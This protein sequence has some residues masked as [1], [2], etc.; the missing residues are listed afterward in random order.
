M[1]KLFASV[2][3]IAM[4]STAAF[5]GT[6]ADDCSTFEECKAVAIAAEG[7]V[8]S[9]EQDIEQY[10]DLYTEA[11]ATAQAEVAKVQGLQ[12]EIVTYYNLLAEANAEI[13]E[14]EDDAYA[15]GV[16][17]GHV[18]GH[19]EGFEAATEVVAEFYNTWISGSDKSLEDMIADLEAEWS[20]G[21]AEAAENAAF[22][23]GY[24][25]GYSSGYG[26]AESDYE[27]QIEDLEATISGYLS[28]LAAYIEYWGGTVRDA[29]DS[30]KLVNDLRLTGIM[31]GKAE[32]AE[33][34]ADLETEV[35]DIQDA[36]NDL[37]SSWSISLSDPSNIPLAIEKIADKANLAG[38]YEGLEVGNEDAEAAYDLA[39]N[40]IVT[41]FNEAFNNEFPTYITFG[42][43][44]NDIVE[45][46]SNAAYSKVSSEFNQLIKNEGFQLQHAGGS[47]WILSNSAGSWIVDLGDIA[48]QA[49]N[50]VGV[51]GVEFDEET[52]YVT[53]TLTN[54]AVHSNLNVTNQ[55]NAYH[56][57]QIAESKANDAV[58]WQV[59]HELKGELFAA[60]EEL[61]EANATIAQVKTAFKHFTNWLAEYG[62]AA[63][64]IEQS[65][66]NI[67][68]ALNK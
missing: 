15:V 37:L 2:A 57:E 49:A 52:S 1:K 4:S 45:G 66:D 58:W 55:I 59:N 51:A 13:A 23:K 10:F 40:A 43:S 44:V 28:G 19:V 39:Y 53:I 20:A 32:S 3:I 41:D 42:N 16:A 63:W 14:L 56:A 24:D 50:S 65:V 33:E 6:A 38:Y 7:K 54:G 35:A 61:E 21:L 9:L 17:D 62:R 60:R 30:G 5:A 47:E 25:A 12:D 31:L 11:Q 26:I 27:P 46:V 34:I 22:N 18:E 48:K 67:S 36:V 64:V 29:T 68:N 8:Q